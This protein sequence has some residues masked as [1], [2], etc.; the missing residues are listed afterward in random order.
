MSCAAIMTPDPLTI[1][2]DESVAEAVDKLVAQPHANLPVVDES[3]RYA[4]MFG[5]CDLLGLLVPRV[6]LA[7]NLM[8]NLRFVVDD[9]EELR[10]KFDAV[11]NRRVGEVANRNAV[12]LDSEASE[13]EAFRLF[14]RSHDSLAVVEKPS[15]RVVGM[16]SP[17]N[18]IRALASPPA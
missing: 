8:S 3:G 2:D 4:G 17:W 12:T 7:G 5:L 9:P 11:K 15:G 13:I 1:R 14:C 6:A 10:R 16:V 18:A